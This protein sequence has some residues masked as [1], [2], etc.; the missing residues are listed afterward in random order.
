MIMEVCV[1]VVGFGFRD[2]LMGTRA[3]SQRGVSLAISADDLA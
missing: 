1:V 2:L 3:L